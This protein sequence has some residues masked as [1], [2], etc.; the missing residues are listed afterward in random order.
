MEDERL[1]EK[2]EMLLVDFTENLAAEPRATGAVYEEITPSSAE[3][4][5]SLMGTIQTISSVVK[6]KPLPEGF[7]A[8]I[9]DVAQERFQEQIPSEKIQQIIGMAVSREDF[10]RSFFQDIAAACR[11][12]GL[13][14]TPTEMAALRTLREDL[15]DDFANS[16]DERITKFFPIDLA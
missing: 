3:E 10:R 9:C 14:L 2:L 7:A 12:I 15:V 16:L 4:A 1:E 6:P 11:G 13:S 5:S 8:R